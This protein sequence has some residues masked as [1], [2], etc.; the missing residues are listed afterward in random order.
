MKEGQKAPAM[1]LVHGGGGHPYAEWIRRWNERGYVAIAMDTT[2]FFPGEEIK[3]LH[4][5]EAPK[6]ERK[7]VHELYGKLAEDGYSVGPDNTEM[8]DYEE[9]IGDQW[10][11]HAVSAT[12]L[13]HNILRQDPLVDVNKIGIVGISWGGVITSIAMGYDHRYAFAVPIYGS[14]YLD[15]LHPADIMDMFSHPIVKKNWSASKRFAKVAYPVL[16]LCYCRDTCFCFGANSLSYKDTKHSGSYFSNRYH[17]G[18]SHVAGWN[19]EEVYRFAE[20]MNK[21]K[22]PLIKAQSEPSGFG[23]ISFDI[24]IPEDFTDVSAEIYYITEP[25]QYDVKSEIQNEF[26]TVKMKLNEKTVSGFIPEEAYGYYVEFQGSVN[27][28]QYIS[29]TA[30]VEK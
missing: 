15:K 29:T 14:G 24:V 18:H 3:G 12:I 19:A 10:M 20:G 22:V 23:E 5:T 9:P 11:Y 26:Y 2:G 17:M 28:N 30:W 25:I 7:Y 27:E 4:G 21:K 8:K 16:W 13:A 1:V 6:E